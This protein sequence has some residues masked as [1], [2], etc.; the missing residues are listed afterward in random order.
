MHT[1]TYVCSLVKLNA[2]LK[3]FTYNISVEQ[4]DMEGK[5]LDLDC[6][7]ICSRTILDIIYF[8]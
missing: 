8:P 5:S 1:H 6:E 7:E 4:Q 2:V 3:D